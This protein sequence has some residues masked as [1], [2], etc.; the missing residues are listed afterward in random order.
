MDLVHTSQRGLKVLQG[1][2]P[3]D[4]MTVLL[5]VKVICKVQIH[6]AAKRYL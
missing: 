6:C 2:T 4:V 5:V 3:S 1:H